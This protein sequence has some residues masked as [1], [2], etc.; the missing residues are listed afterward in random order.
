MV[1][2][3]M[4]PFGYPMDLYH[5]LLDEQPHY[6]VPAWLMEDQEPPVGLIVNP[7]CWLS[8]HGPLGA[9]KSVRIAFAEHFCPSDCIVWVASG[10]NGTVW[11]FWLG[12][13]YYSYLSDL[14]PGYPAPVDLPDDVFWVL[15]KANILVDASH[16]KQERLEWLRTVRELT[17]LFQR[18]FLTLSGLIHPFHIG[19]LRRYYRYHTRVGS[20][21]FGDSQV[22]RRYAAHNETVARFFHHQLAGVISDLADNVLKP[23]YAYFAAYQSDAELP[24]HVDREQCEYSI[25]IC[26]DASPE[27]EDQNPWPID[28]HTPDG[29][30]RIWQRIGDG[31]LY[32]GRYIPHSRQRLPDGYASSSMVFHYVDEAHDDTLD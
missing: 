20:F 8:W 19:A 28:L 5:C 23:S 17:P 9:D 13:E 15:R 7:N 32:R 12:P 30:L 2:S 27:P 1:A 3:M 18:G 26:I 4:T 21:A 29:L 22:S 31:L 24:W 11:P 25:S 10:A 6:L 14:A 16:D